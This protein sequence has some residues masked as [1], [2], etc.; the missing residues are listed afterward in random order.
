MQLRSCKSTH[1]TAVSVV[2]TSVPLDCVYLSCVAKKHVCVSFE[3]EENAY[4]SV[5]W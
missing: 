5:V 2:N 1:S 4:S 3:A